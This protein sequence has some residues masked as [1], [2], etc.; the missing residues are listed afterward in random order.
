[1]KNNLA[2][3]MVTTAMFS[4]WCLLIV[5]PTASTLKC[6]TGSKQTTPEGIR[7]ISREIEMTLYSGKQNQWI[8]SYT[9]RPINQACIMVLSKH[10][11][12]TIVAKSGVRV[13]KRLRIR[14]FRYVVKSFAT[15]ANI[16]SVAA[17][18]NKLY[19]R[20]SKCQY[21][22]FYRCRE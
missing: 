21:L 5:I 18:V 14:Y 9:T 19:R 8:L 7:T 13:S 20:L 12:R 17:H 10:H 3:T 15:Y 16:Q 11:R 4:I 2:M 6:D 22:S 1:M